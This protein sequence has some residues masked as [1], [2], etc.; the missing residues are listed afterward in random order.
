MFVKVT[1]NK[2]TVY[3]IKQLR[4]DNP[5]V[6]F[7]KEPNEALLAQW[8]VYPYTVMSVGEFDS[9]AWTIVDDEIV[10]ENNS[11]IQKR[12]LEAK[13]LEEAKT[14]IR[15]HR[16]SLL[17]ECDWTQLADATVDSL[18]WANYRQALRDVPTQEGFP[19]NVTWPTKPE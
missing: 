5:N 13:P 11:W 3:S 18:A 19:Y 6:S 7:P 12:K 4:K 10:Y 17:S 1:D 8:N 16:N 9:L 14:S 2:A 15:D